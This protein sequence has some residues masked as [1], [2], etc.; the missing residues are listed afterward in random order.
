MG[1]GS[2]IELARKSNGLSMRALAEKMNLSAMAISKYERGIMNPSSSVLLQLADVLH[3]N[4]EYFFRPAPEAVP[5]VVYRKHTSLK[6]NQTER[7]SCPHSGMAGAL[8]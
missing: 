7:H 8:S 4:I 6:K 2:R 3:V 1:I 5:L